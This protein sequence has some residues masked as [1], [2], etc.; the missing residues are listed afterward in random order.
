MYLCL[1]KRKGFKYLI[2]AFNTNSETIL[3]IN[4]N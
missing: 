1:D 4:I 2:S 3:V